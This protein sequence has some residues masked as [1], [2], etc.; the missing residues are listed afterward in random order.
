MDT[1]AKAQE[2]AQRLYTIQVWRDET[3]DGQPVYVACSP[4]LEGCMGQGETIEDALADFDEAKVDYIQSLLDDGL[5]VLYPMHATVSAD[6]SAT[7][8]FEHPAN[9]AV[10]AE[11]PSLLY[12]ASLAL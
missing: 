2:L 8:V 10:Q 3:T 5:P 7:F 1:R 9:D 4:E 6:S 12:Q 11:K